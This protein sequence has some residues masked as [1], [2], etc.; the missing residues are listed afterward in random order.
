MINEISDGV[1]ISDHQNSEGKNGII[2]GERA[3]IAID[4][5]TYPEEGRAMADFIK[6]KGYAA[7]RVLLTHGHSDH[8]LGGQAFYHAEVY[9]HIYTPRTIERHLKGFAVSQNLNYDA[10]VEQALKPTICFSGEL[11]IDLGDK[12]LRVFPTPG[13]S[14][15]GVSVYLEA[16]KILFA[17]DSVV[18]AIVPA[19]NDGDSRFLER[20]L[21]QILTMDIE[22]V[23]A[24]HGRPLYGRD[25]IHDW[26]NWT[27]SYLRGV[28]GCVQDQLEQ[29][30]N[31]SDEQITDQVDYDTFIGDRLPKD[32]FNMPQRHRNTVL[33]IIEEERIEN[34]R[35]T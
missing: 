21:R 13:H 7:D 17:A 25:D 23:V 27:L 6:S 19:I 8:V 32:K 2:V 20:T 10:T 12:K 34:G 18:T 11:H 29:D 31:R 15:D 24:G 28:R 33:K 5:G 3:A 9:G 26:L 30:S 14:E 1:F 16:Q 22:L 4:V 35:Q